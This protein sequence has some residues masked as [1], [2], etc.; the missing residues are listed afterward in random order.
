M[1]TPLDTSVVCPILLGRSAHVAALNAVLTQTHAGRGRVVLLS[2]EAGIGKSRLAAE[3]KAY[4]LAGGFDL[5]EGR[6]FESDRAIPYAPLRDLLRTFLITRPAALVATVLGPLALD[7]LPLLPELRAIF[8]DRLRSTEH[9]VVNEPHQ[10]MQAFAQ[11]VSAL[12]SSRPVLAVIEDLH[13]SDDASL[14]AL[15]RLVRHSVHQPLLLLLTYRHDELSPGLTQLLMELDREHAATE[16]VLQPLTP[17]EIDGMLRAIFNLAEPVRSEFLD[18]IAAL[19]EGNPFFIEEVLKSLIASGGIVYA[20]GAW[21]RK[22][23]EALQ[24][25]RSVQAAVQRRLDQLTP[26]ARELITLAAVA[27]RRFEFALLEGIT[28]HTEAELV[29]LMKD[30]VRAQLV[31]EE[32]PDVFAFRHAL[33]RQAVEA[34]LLARERRA[35]H[36]QIVEALE[37]LAA[38]RIDQ[39]VAELASHAYTAEDWQRVLIY[40]DRAG[41]QALQLYALQTAIEHFSHA[42]EA[43]Q[44]LDLRAPTKLYRSRGQAYALLS[45]FA[46]AKADFEQTVTRA[47]E[48]GDQALEWQSLLDLGFLW[49]ARDFVQAGHY[50]NQALALARARSDPNQLAY[51][52]NRL[53]NW[54]VNADQPLRGR[55]YHEEAL[56]LF[57][58]TG[59][60]RGQAETLDLLA[61]ASYLAGDLHGAT[62]FYAQAAARFRAL[63][64][65]VGLASS[66]SWLALCGPAALNTMTAAA[67]L[68]VCIQMAEEALQLARGMSWRSGEAFALIVLGMCLDAQGDYAHALPSLQRGLAI[69]QELNHLTWLTA[70]RFGLGMFY[71][72][73]MMPDAAVEQ[74]EHALDS[75]RESNAPFSIRLQAAGLAIAAL[76]AGDQAR[77]AAILGETFGAD[78]ERDDLPTLAERLGWC[79]QAELGLA[80]D[81]PAMAR[82]ITNWLVATAASAPDIDQPVVPRL[83]LLHGRVLA[84]LQRNDEAEATLLEARTV[85]EAQSAQSLTWQI[86]VALGRLYHSCL[87]RRDAAQAYASARQM[88]EHLAAAISDAGLAAAFLRQA[89]ARM[90]RAA[91]PSPR[92]AAQQAVDGLTEREREVAILVAQGKTNREIAAALVLTERTIKA[93]VGNILGKL[94]LSS[95]TQIVA[96]AIEKGLLGTRAE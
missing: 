5:L 54:H 71:L 59:D 81:Q 1:H 78:A 57:E 68:V 66:L 53:G 87:R 90:P 36:L 11:A 21:D 45:S 42:L 26:Q 85:A 13:W 30:L 60:A 8:E 62:A 41:Q 52:L 48:D 92:R 73:I 49:M 35:L 24:I 28:H 94:G 63:D 69:A 39:R 86:H 29:R 67:S 6:C 9:R 14:D 95:R 10:L 33:T 20:D 55:P 19:T 88:V 64:D 50:F 65:R 16:L 37:R 31:V 61:G 27:G 96:W 56:A 17:D 38:E 70:A 23:L 91:P 74:L 58:H 76:Q 43:A 25:P 4:A 7:L 51:S 47:R 89:T 44:R 93:H 46:A 18:A 82:E 79:V 22:P 12:A 83:L 3:V 72:N 77:A 32:S 15:L 75:A 2:G 80:R 40:A 34:D 84:A